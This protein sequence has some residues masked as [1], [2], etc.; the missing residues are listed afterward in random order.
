MERL[1]LFEGLYLTSKNST[2]PLKAY[3]FL[4]KILSS[5][6][7]FQLNSLETQYVAGIE[8]WDL[9]VF[10]VEEMEMVLSEAKQKGLEVHFSKQ[11]AA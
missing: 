11:G 8:N 2:S 1:E 5:C 4:K 9:G 3:I 10:Y 7:H 6:Q